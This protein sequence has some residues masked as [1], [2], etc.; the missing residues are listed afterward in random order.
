M[1]ARGF[2]GDLAA[3]GLG[4]E[5]LELGHGVLLCFRAGSQGD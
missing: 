1:N 2:A 3:L 5:F 4:K